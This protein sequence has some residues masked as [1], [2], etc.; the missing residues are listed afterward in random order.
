MGQSKKSR[1][2]PA[3]SRDIT[4]AECGENRHSRYACPEACPFNPFA[5]ANYTAL[6]QAEN[7]LD[8][9][10]LKR[11]AG[12][13]AAI[14]QTI[15]EARRLNEGHGWHAAIAW[16]LFFQ[17]DG[18]GRTFA[19]RWQLAGFPGLKNDER[20]FFRAKMQMR[21]ALIEVHRILDDQRIEAV[22]LLDPTA[23][24]MI[25]IDRSVAARA[26]R[27]ATVLT[28]IYPLPHFGRMSGTGITMSDLGPFSP[29]EMLD[30]CVAHLGGPAG[31]EERRRWLAENFVRIDEALLATGLE[32]RRQML[33][34]MDA[35]F[36]A[37]TYELLAPFIDC[38]RALVADP[39]IAVD[40]VHE[41]ERE[42][43]FAEA[44]VWF[45]PSPAGGPASALIPGRRVLGRVLL[46][47]N[48]WRV[49]AIGG[50]RLDQL[51]ERFEARLGDR[52]RFVKERRDNIA[53]Q[54]ASREPTANLAL[55]P[56]RL[57]ERPNTF[58]MASSRVEAP[59]AGVPLET[60]KAELMSRHRRAWLDE[61]LPALDGRTAREA[62]KMP[63]LRA[64]LLELVKG[65]VRQV[66]QLNFETGRADD[67]N[68]IIRE[69][70]LAEIDFPPPPR[71]PVAAAAESDEGL[72]D[73]D[74]EE[75]ADLP[76]PPRRRPPGAAAG[77]SAPP[78]PDRPLTFAESI[79]RL[80]AGLDAFETAADAMEEIAASGSTLL[81]CAHALTKGQI[82]E[83]GYEPLT[84]LLMQVWFALVPRGGRAPRLRLDAMMAEINQ[85]LKKIR[86]SGPRGMA[87]LPRMFSESPQPNVLHAVAGTLVE[88]VEKAPKAA[89]P[90]PG[91][92]VEMMLVLKAMIAEIDCGL[93]RP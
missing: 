51:R 33:A 14:T 20:V 91:M 37:A 79:G 73:G 60:Y 86:A 61:R 49:Q 55:V 75:R 74:A 29:L 36:G 32:R 28:W 52:V 10:C 92:V 45:E 22:D 54:L 24:P 19:D 13:D 16:H 58:D 12:E 50:A 84:V 89:R 82:N 42:K 81:E 8:L 87:D 71:R 48:D 23:T 77:W 44:M 5:P 3:V 27:F 90:D 57:L 69:L 64:R 31:I 9:T 41:D 15:A 25:L 72:E 66:D 62:A 30:A 53:G 18:N 68:A 17:R 38:R 35:S 7:A 21:V 26:V 63:A 80:R 67:V 43:G 46:G 56:P 59:A 85:D 2:C 6:L 93:R 11:C 88:S 34:R 4:S 76:H 70:E 65:L 39:A 47:F 83:R 1:S 40:D 78:L